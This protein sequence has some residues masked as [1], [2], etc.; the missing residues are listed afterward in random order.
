M[1]IRLPPGVQHHRFTVDDY[2]RMIDLGIL[3]EDHPVELIHGEVVYKADARSP[4]F[5]HTATTERYRFTVDEYERLIRAGILAEEDRVELIHGEVVKKMSIGPRHAAVV[6]RLIRLFGGQ[7]QGRAQLGAQ[8]PVHLADSEPEP[9]LSILRPSPDDYEAHHPTPAD[10]FLLIEV[11]ES[12]F[13]AD[14][15]IQGPLYARNGI[16]EYWIINLNDDTVHVHRGPQ[17]DGTYASVQQHA[18]GATLTVAALPGVAVAV[19]DILP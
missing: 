18:R 15:D 9:D 14:R 11:A 8:D 1:V 4:E 6:K 3:T 16:V 17:A 13:V 2:H 12:S 5:R 7:I 19:T 10:V